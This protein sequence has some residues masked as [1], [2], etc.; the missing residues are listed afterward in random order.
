MRIPDSK[1]KQKTKIIKD[2]FC[3]INN[4]KKLLTEGKIDNEIKDKM[5]LKRKII[6]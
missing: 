4:I 1:N 2:L 3:K 5:K 6:N